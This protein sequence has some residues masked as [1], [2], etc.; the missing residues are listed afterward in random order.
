[1]PDHEATRYQTLK[2]VC[3]LIGATP[4]SKISFKYKGNPRSVYIKHESY[5]L[6]GS[7]KDR[8]ALFIL[9]KAMQEEVLSPGDGIYEAS[10]GN[11]GISFAAV[12]R[13]L[14]HPVKIFMPDWMSA[15]RRRLIESYGAEVELVSREE[16]GFQGS[17][18]KSKAQAEATKGFLPSQFSNH[19]NC[20]AHYLTTGPEIHYQLEALDV[21]PDAFIAG[22]GTGGTVMGVGQYLKER[23]PGIRV[24]PLEPASSPTLSTGYK[25][26]S[27][28]IQGISDEFIPDIVDLDSLDDVVHVHDG[29]AIL[30]AQKIASVL[31]Q[32]VGISSGA[33]FIGA[34]KVQESLG[35]DAVVVSLFPD[36]NKKY[37]S[38]DLM[39]EEPCK[40]GYLTPDITELHLENCVSVRNLKT[41]NRIPLICEAE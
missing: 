3:E 6:T 26:G 29:D 31:G 23:H 13:F 24:H 22:V 12:G 11:A 17:I 38:T 20:R 7:V 25:V 5:N 33:N 14:G 35:N 9:Y 8:M 18:E 10:S 39:E 16:G 27:H 36:D 37:L 30:M 34:L 1:M 4:L 15:E 41:R 28:R 32:G 19:A 40:D 21:A 2:H